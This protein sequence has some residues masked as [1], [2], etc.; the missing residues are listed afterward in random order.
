MN[1]ALIRI[2]KLSLRMRG[3]TAGDA[4]LRAHSIAREIAAAVATQG[5]HITPGKTEIRS[6]SVRL[7]VDG[8]GTDMAQ[9]IRSQWK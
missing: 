5:T 3:V 9:Q 4:Q 8:K 6:L 7:R 2:P 1:S